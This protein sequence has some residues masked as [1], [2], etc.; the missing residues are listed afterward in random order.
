MLIK[1]LIDVVI[2][3]LRAFEIEKLSKKAIGFRRTLLGASFNVFL[4]CIV[5]SIYHTPKSDENSDNN[6]NNETN[7]SRYLKH[8]I[9]NNN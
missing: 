9:D 5:T 6:T 7:R 1:F 8:T 4:R 2:F 3:I